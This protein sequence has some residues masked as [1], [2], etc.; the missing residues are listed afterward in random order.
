MALTV[1]ILAAGKGT[2]MNS[3]LPKVLQPIAG[4]PLLAHVLQQAQHLAAN[5][6]I[7]VYGHGGDLVQKTF[8]D[9]AIDWVE[10]AEQLGTGHAVKVTLPV[11]PTSGQSLILYGDVPLI[12][13]S[14]L[15]RLQQ[16]AHA[17]FAMLT[18]HLDHPDN[19]GRIKRD[20]RGRVV[21][22]VEQKD[23]SAQ[24]LAIQ[25][26]NTGIYCID[27]AML[28]RLLPQLNTQ[29][30]QGEYYLTDIVA[31]AAAEGIDI[32]TIQPELDFEIEGVNDRLQLSALERTFQ[33]HQ[34]Q[35]LMKAGVT[36]FDPARFDLRGT[37][38]VGQDVRIDINVIIEGDCSLGDGVQ[39]GAGCVLK[40][41]HIAAG[42]VVLPYSVFEN[43]QIGAN[44]SI[45]PFSRFRPNC[46]L[47]DDVHVGNFVEVKN[48]HMA[49]GSKAGHLAYLGDAKIG[50]DSNIGAG[51]ITCN[52]DGAYKHQTVIGDRAFIGS[53]SALV[54]PVSI[55]HGATVG[56]GS[57]ITKDVPDQ[58]LAVARGQQRNISNYQR[59]SKAK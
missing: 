8:A 19:Y 45:G 34:A 3:R 55:G 51:T 43:S 37:L 29:N 6:T 16:A 9:Q 13:A 57:V 7:V 40:N 31:M 24:E 27:N 21:Q 17:G 49:Q 52:Y 30:A 59:P 4:K 53:N 32:Q 33:L 41:T 47:A 46:V 35:Q 44:N 22:V 5:R 36:L 54:A 15:R 58:Q 20:A 39:L 12:Q 10:Q 48:S 28:H 18:S 42:T 1:I 25:E 26:I 11:L 50:Q 23:A 2:R 56:A 38:K 14:T